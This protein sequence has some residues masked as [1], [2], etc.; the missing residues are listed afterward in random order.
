VTSYSVFDYP[1]LIRES[2]LDT[3]GH[4]NNAVYLELLEEARWEMLT[5]GGFG[6]RHIQESGLGPTILEIT[7]KYKRELRLRSRIAVRTQLESYERKVGILRQWI[8]DDT[9]AVCCDA[10][11]TVGIFDL[12][13]R[14]LVAPPEDWM[15]A[16][17]AQ[18]SGS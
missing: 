1:V 8:E 14:K 17:G 9:G 16:L 15:R 10:R 7:I 4:V 6:M 3:L 18:S 12:K 11:L 2:H 5:A 13:T